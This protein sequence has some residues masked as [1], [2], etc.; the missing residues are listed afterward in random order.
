MEAFQ[1]LFRYLLRL[2]AELIPPTSLK[3]ALYRLSGIQIGKRVHIS[4]G[5]YVADGFR[6]GWVELEDQ[7]VLSPKVILVP[8]SHPNT[9]YIAEVWQV[10]KRGKIRIKKGAW[11]G[12]GAV[13]LPGVT[14]GEGAI[15]GANAVVNRDVSDFAI[16]AGVPARQLGDVRDKPEVSEKWW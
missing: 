1:Q 6:S 16:V 13:V 9:S 7:V 15:V 8:S 12:A 4:P 10:S 2:I 5:V 14:I 11:I 3:S